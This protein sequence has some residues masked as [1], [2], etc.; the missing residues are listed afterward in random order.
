MPFLNTTN[1]SAKINSL[2]IHFK[3][4]YILRGKYKNDS[5]VFKSKYN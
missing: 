1:V 4:E 2:M 3:E 5:K